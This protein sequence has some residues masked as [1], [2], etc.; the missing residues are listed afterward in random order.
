[1]DSN[2]VIIL[3]IRVPSLPAAELTGHSSCINSLAWYSAAPPT[4]STAWR[5]ILTAAIGVARAPHSSCHLATAGDDS[6]ALI[7]DLS[8]MPKPIEGTKRLLPHRRIVNKANQ[9]IIVC[10]WLL[11]RPHSGVQCRGRGESA[12]V[13]AGPARLDLHRLCLQN[14]DPPRLSSSDTL[15]HNPAR[16]RAENERTPTTTNADEQ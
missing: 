9:P 5:F 2:K 11:I 6:S 15:E 14:A 3:D 4:T 1:M 13:V 12:A 16:T 8:S 7:W 10:F